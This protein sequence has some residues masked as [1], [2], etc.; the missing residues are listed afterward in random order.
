MKQKMISGILAALCILAT[1]QAGFSHNIEREL[2]SVPV[3]GA[4]LPLKIPVGVWQGQWTLEHLSLDLFRTLYEK[5]PHGEKRDLFGRLIQGQ[6]KQLYLIQ[7]IYEGIRLPGSSDLETPPPASHFPEQASLSD[8]LITGYE[9]MAIA[10]EHHHLKDLAA[11]LLEIE[12]E[13]IRLLNLLMDT[14]GSPS[15]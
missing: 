15:R 2:S 11:L 8:P 3:E 1:G 14:Q 9:W 7:T 13:Q 12:R 5:A 6:I 4:G 10:F